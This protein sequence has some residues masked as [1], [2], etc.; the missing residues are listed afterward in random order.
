[1]GVNLS[2]NFNV[3]RVQNAAAAAATPLVGT[4]VDMQGWDNVVFI[5]GVGALT[6]TQVTALKAQNGN[7]VGDGDQADITGAI[8]PAMADGDSNRLLV[9][10][11]VRPL[12]RYVRPTLNRA[13]ANAVVDFGIAIQYSG[14]K[15]PPAALDATVSQLLAA[16]GV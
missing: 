16:V 1:M 12:L 6:A 14:D 7:A 8:T 4:H 10:E 9:L 5:Y 13:T 11:V 3:V 2:K 15:V